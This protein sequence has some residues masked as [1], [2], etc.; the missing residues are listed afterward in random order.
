M[1]P[2]ENTLSP[3][4]S[5]GKSRRSPWITVYRT[6]VV[7]YT[8]LVLPYAATIAVFFDNGTKFELALYLGSM[9]FLL[10]GAWCTMMD[11]WAGMVAGVI[12]LAM[13]LAFIFTYQ[14][15]SG[16]L[17]SHPI[18]LLTGAGLLFLLGNGYLYMQQ[19]RQ[20]GGSEATIDHK[21]TLIAMVV[22]AAFPF[23]L[24]A[25]ARSFLPALWI[26]MLC[27]I[28][29]VIEK[30]SVQLAGVIAI[31]LTICG[32]FVMVSAL[33]VWNVWDMLGA[34]IAMVL[35]LVLLRHFARAHRAS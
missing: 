20:S 25:P 14:G 2:H 21:A 1:P 33:I 7:L 16:S 23:T 17:S 3:V 19:R 29:L 12:E 11:A 5:S 9:V 24:V 28:A 10:V 22:L 15:W 6:L 35:P 8:I 30:A 32:V 27:P 26:G 31:V 34:V 4:A 13:C 18:A